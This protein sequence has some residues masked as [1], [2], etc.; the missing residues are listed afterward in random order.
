MPA[1]PFDAGS[2]SSLHGGD[3]ELGPCRC[4]PRR[5]AADHLAAAPLLPTPRHHLFHW[6]EEVT[7]TTAAVQRKKREEKQQHSRGLA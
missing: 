2:S 6:D 1:S 4:S 7:T 5:T 3:L